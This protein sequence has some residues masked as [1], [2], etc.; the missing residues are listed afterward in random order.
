MDNK[1][2]KKMNRLELLEILVQQGERIEE[3]EAELKKTKAE[4]ASREIRLEKAGSIADAALQITDIFAR[5]QDAADLYLENVKRNAASSAAGGAGTD[6]PASSETQ[7][8]GAPEAMPSENPEDD[9]RQEERSIL[10]AVRARDDGSGSVE[11]ASR[12][13][14]EPVRKPVPPQEMEEEPYREPS[15]AE[16]AGR[17]EKTDSRGPKARSG[18]VREP[19]RSSDETP[20]WRIYD[21]YEKE[22]DEDGFHWLDDI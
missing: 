13:R 16:P 8:G 7:A 5:A 22:A 15:G 4:L 17:R 21:N 12:R 14:Q 9:S 2:L 1:E 18:S 20:A 19:E 6:A 11:G 10:F 3:L